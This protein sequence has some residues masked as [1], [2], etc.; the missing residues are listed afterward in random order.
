MCKNGSTKLGKNEN[1]ANKVNSDAQIFI[2]LTVVEWLS[3]NISILYKIL[4]KR[5]ALND[6][7]LK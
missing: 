6:F 1:G 5:T 7:E 2:M 4:V 3:P